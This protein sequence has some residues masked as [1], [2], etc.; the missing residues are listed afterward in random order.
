[1]TAVPK[2][3]LTEDEYLSIE[4]A[5]EFKSEFY[6]GEMFAMAGASIAHNFIRDNLV[7]RLNNCFE[8]SPGRCRTASGD[9]RVKV[10]RTGLYTYPDVIIICGRTEVDP[11]ASDTLLNPH[12]IFEILS[13]ST[14]SYDRGE[15]FLHYRKLPSLREYVLVSQKEMLIDRFVRQEDDSWNLITF[16]ATSNEFALATVPVRIP[17]ALVYRD[18]EL[19]GKVDE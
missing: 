9:L 3:K 19:P 7:Q 14:E 10:D 6:N 5:A 12:V 11:K 13:D 18:V 16:D 17:M 4:R 8:G 15:K 2:K 1:M